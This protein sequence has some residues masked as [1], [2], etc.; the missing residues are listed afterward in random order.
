MKEFFGSKFELHRKI[1]IGRLSVAMATVKKYPAS[2]FYAEC[3][4]V[5][6]LQIWA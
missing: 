5:S 6:T 3:W 4:Y 1:Q 2:Q